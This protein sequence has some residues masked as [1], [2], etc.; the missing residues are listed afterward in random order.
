MTFN[1]YWFSIKNHAR[2]S[3]V[4]YKSV[5]VIMRRVPD[6]YHSRKQWLQRG[7]LQRPARY[8]ITRSEM[9]IAARV[10]I[11][12]LTFCLGPVF[13]LPARFLFLSLSFLRERFFIF[14]FDEKSEEKERD[15]LTELNPLFLNAQE[16]ETSL[17]FS[18]YFHTILHVETKFHI[19]NIH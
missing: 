15:T 19:N 8:A 17:R 3:H 18:I 11:L 16:R 9:R 13:L 10:C 4:D 1:R 5:G 12:D 2:Q 7:R 14:S 6:I